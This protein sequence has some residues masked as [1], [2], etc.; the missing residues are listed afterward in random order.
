MH[1]STDPVVTPALSTID[2]LTRAQQNKVFEFS[3]LILT[4][5]KQ[6]EVDYIFGVPG[7]AIEPLYNALARSERSG[8]PRSLVARHETGA[9][10][11]AEGYS[12]ETGKLGVCCATTGPG[13]T[14]L[15][16]G[17]TSAYLEEQ[18]LLIITAQTPLETFGRGAVQESSCT[19]VNTV[20]MFQQ[21]TRYN[22]LVSH[23]KQ[24]ESK[25]V[26]AIISAFGAP[27]GPSHLSIPLDMLRT[28]ANVERPTYDLPSSLR[29]GSLMDMVAINRLFQELST[30]R[31]TVFLV[32]K[33][34]N[35]AIESIFEL[36]TWLNAPVVTT[37]QG[38]CAVNSFHPM[39]RGIFGAAGH[40]DARRVI[41][42]SAV[43]LIVAIGTELDELDSSGWDVDLLCNK[44]IH[45]DSSA[46]H[47]I[48]SPMARLHV[49][50]TIKTLF[51]HLLAQF[52]VNNALFKAPATS[53]DHAQPLST[54]AFERRNKS[55]RVI[56]DRRN[57]SADG[58]HKKPVR[59]F[60][61]N[62][63]EKY[64][65]TS[66]PIK[67]Q[68]L[69]YDLSRLFPPNTRFLADTGNSF[70]WAAHYLHPY[71]RRLTSYRTPRGGTLRAGMAYGSMCWAIGAAIGTALAKPDGPVVCIT[72]DGSMLMSGQEITVAVA[73]QLPVIFIVLNDHALGTVKHGQQLAKAEPIGYELPA[74]DF[75]QYARSIGASSYT[76]FSPDDLQAL[77]IQAI[78]ERDGPTLLDVR[79]DPDEVPPIKG[80]IEMLNASKND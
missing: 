23:P 55:Q 5:L 46:Q 72:G 31:H 25:L 30:S 24:L 78:C 75:S 50:G 43:E 71:D 15:L 56:T 10:F 64:L 66:T 61:L 79:I 73:H 80:R 47:F 34:C 26:S 21:R 74:I 32:G 77:D 49:E 17:V 35:N 54:H 8:G 27:A 37:P 40:Q 48:R 9:A 14:N 6:I 62:D 60:K 7:G 68:R 63:E 53:N 39:F 29:G 22:T 20:N 70:F 51:E 33:R 1:S 58:T 12:R 65:D 69:M 57:N 59:H 18:P 4:Y 19:G 76:I 45:I 11:M 28:P 52:N 16:T 3:D 41:K 36:A 38:R 44:L 13:A 2:T 67:P 42:D